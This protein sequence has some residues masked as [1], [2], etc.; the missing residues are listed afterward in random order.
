[1]NI[2]GISLCKLLTIIVINSSW[3]IMYLYLKWDQQE[4]LITAIVK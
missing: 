1:M 2:F 3:E 4:A